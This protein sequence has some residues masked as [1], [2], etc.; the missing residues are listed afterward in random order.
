ML[1]DTRSLLEVC[2]PNVQSLKVLGM[3][4]D[5]SGQYHSSQLD[6]VTQCQVEESRPDVSEDVALE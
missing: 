4:G 6:P 5:T 3:F 2:L 1:L